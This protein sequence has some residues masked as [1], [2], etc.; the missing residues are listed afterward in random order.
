MRRS[1][2]FAGN[3]REQRTLADMLEALEAPPGARR[4]SWTAWRRQDGLRAVVA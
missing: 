1:K 3:V 2:V 4:E